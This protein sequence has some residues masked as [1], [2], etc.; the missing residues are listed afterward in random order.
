M[1]SKIHAL[2]VASVLSSGLATT[3]TA[4]TMTFTNAEPTPVMTMV[5]DDTV[6]AGNLRF[7]LSTTVGT[8]D[9]LAL[10]FNFS[11]TS[12][13]QSDISF[14][15]ATREDD[16]P[17]IVDL[18]LFGD[19][20]LSQNVCGGGCNFNGAGSATLFDYIIRI[21]E[22]GGGGQGGINFVKSV[23]FDIS[24]TANLANS[25]FSGFAVRAQS[26]SNSSGS[27]KTNLVPDIPAVPVPASLPLLAFGLIGSGL[28]ARRRKARY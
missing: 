17:S 15:S 27:I 9:Y 22:N 11:G 6:S 21:G 25:P 7:S 23:V 8:A 20:S 5:V 24:S 28:V 10:A 1:F 19:N 2:V 16:S 26:T 3:A 14:V 13:N 12:L 18:E 4:A